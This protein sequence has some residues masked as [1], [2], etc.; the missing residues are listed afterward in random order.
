[1]W[2]PAD[3]AERE[4]EVVDEVDDGDRSTLASTVSSSCLV[5]DIVGGDDYGVGVVGEQ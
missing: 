1:M 2:W 4:Y 5:E 3:V